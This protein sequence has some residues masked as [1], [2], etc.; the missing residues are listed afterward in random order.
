MRAFSAF[1]AKELMR[2]TNAARGEVQPR[3]ASQP[4]L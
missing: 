3:S 1:V 4:V 2:S